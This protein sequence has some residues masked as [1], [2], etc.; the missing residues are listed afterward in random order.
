MWPSRSLKEGPDTSS[1]I[2][3][4]ANYKRFSKREI[5]DVFKMETMEFIVENSAGGFTY[6]LQSYFMLTYRKT[7]NASK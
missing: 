1:S 6:V 3:L 2:L 5:N 4:D 7:T